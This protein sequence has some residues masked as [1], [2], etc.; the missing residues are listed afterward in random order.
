M[1]NDN[2][3]KELKRTLRVLSEEYHTTKNKNVFKAFIYINNLLIQE[4]SLHSIICNIK[5]NESNNLTM[6]VK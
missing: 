3:I 5:D 6:S 2:T 4:L 1:L